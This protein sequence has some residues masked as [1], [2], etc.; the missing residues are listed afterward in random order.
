MPPLAVTGYEISLWIHISAVVVGFGATFA[1]SIAFPVAMRLDARHLPYVHRLQLAINQYLATPALVVILVT[2]IYQV[3]DADLDFGDFWISASFA[4]LIVLG[5]L[6]GAYFIPADRRLGPMVQRDIDRAGDG[7]VVLSDEYQRAA[8]TEGI[9]GMVA[10]LLVI[11]VI[12]L[13]V[14]K[15]GL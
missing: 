7:Q 9:V 15:P 14:T 3:S 5:G 10:G 12:Y 11:V 2:G 8:R 13:M 6:L 4:I 1:E